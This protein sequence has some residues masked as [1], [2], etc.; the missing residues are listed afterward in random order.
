MD[1]NGELPEKYAR[2]AQYF[3]HGFG[4]HRLNAGENIPSCW[5]I[6]QGL[7]TSSDGSQV[8][9]FLERAWRKPRDGESSCLL[10]VCQPLQAKSG[11]PLLLGLP[12]GAA[13]G[14]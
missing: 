4:V 13:G 3:L 9:A 2:D 5:L 7:R 6:S 12:A 1:E 14:W 10:R 8:L 11:D